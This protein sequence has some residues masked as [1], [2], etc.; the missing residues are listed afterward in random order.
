MHI[1]QIYA[2]FSRPI[3]TVISCLDFCDGQMASLSTL[4]LISFWFVLHTASRV[5]V[6]KIVG[7]SDPFPKPFHALRVRQTL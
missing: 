2:F 5:R 6:F 3:K 4:L 1:F 7:H